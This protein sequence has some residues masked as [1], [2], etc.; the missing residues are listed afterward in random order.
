MI[1]Y[2]LNDTLCESRLKDFESFDW[3]VHNYKI[4]DWCGDGCAAALKDSILYIYNLGH[5][6][7]YGPFEFG[8][9][10]SFSI[11]EF[12]YSEDIFTGIINDDKVRNKVMELVK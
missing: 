4:G 9:F 11:Q 7:C 2:C 3:I 12:L 8:Y 6:S 10:D 1:E 5:C